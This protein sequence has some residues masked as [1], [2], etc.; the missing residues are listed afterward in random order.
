[1]KKEKNVTSDYFTTEEG[2]FIKHYSSCGEAMR[3]TNINHST[4]VRAAKAKRLGKNFYWI[5]DN[6][7]LTINDLL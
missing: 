3:E 4:I 2:K 6:Q 1:M 5:L 7:T